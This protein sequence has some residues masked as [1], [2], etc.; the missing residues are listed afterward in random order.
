MSDTRDII[1]EH[2][3]RPKSVDECILPEHVQKIANGWVSNG[4][5]P[6]ALFIGSA[7]CGKTTLAQAMAHQLDVDFMKIRASSEGNIDTVRNKMSGFA[8]TASFS[9]GKKILLLDEADGLT[10]KAQEA[11][12]GFFDDY[13]SNVSVIMTA[14]FASKIIE[15]LKSRSKVLSF[16]AKPEERNVMSAKFL[17]RLVMMLKAEGV[18]YDVRVL[19]ELI[20]EKFPDFRSVINEVQ[21]YASGSKVIDSGILVDVDSDLI[22]SLCAALKAKKA[23]DVRRWVAENGMTDPSVLYGVIYQY[24]RELLEPSSIP[25]FIILLAKYEYQSAFVAN[26]EINLMAFMMEVMTSDIRWK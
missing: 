23:S 22:S 21:G 6:V 7:G 1:W 9:G 10:T 24:A 13:A 26:Q 11:L 3:Y 17:K 18:E 15:P 8:S 16:R 25:E 2:K 20:T 14:N 12:R 19:G 4:D 5:I